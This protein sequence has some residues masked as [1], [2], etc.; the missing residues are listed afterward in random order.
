M[1]AHSNAE[2]KLA[3]SPPVEL[4]RI[5]REQLLSVTLQ[6]A[7][8]NVPA[9]AYISQHLTSIT[10]ID[11]LRLLQIGCKETMVAEPEAFRN[12]GQATMLV[13]HSGGTSGQQLVMYR[14]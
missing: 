1:A 9:Y 11:D 12:S 8:R 3:G 2:D 13:Q 7:S 6:N 14:S 5:F 10:C 4:K